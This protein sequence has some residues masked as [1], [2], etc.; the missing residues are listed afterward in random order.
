VSGEIA[1]RSCSAID[2]V[3]GMDFAVMRMYE[4]DVEGGS[5]DTASETV[6]AMLGRNVCVPKRVL[7]MV[8]PLVAAAW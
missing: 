3:E 1:G 8:K 7:L 6:R 4:K 5:W 2:G